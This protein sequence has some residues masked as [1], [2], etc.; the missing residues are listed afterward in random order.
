MAIHSPL[1]EKY[2]AELSTEPTGSV[3][4]GMASII[5][6]LSEPRAFGYLTTVIL[7]DQGSPAADIAA[8]IWVLA[9]A[10]EEVVR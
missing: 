2:L 5:R 4:F 9:A 7:D 3:E 10:A 6:R 1:C 8:H